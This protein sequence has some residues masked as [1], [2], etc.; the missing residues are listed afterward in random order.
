[1]HIISKIMRV[2]QKGNVRVAVLGVFGK[3]ALACAPTCELLFRDPIEA[4]RE[5]VEEIKEKEDADFDR[6]Y[7]AQRDMGG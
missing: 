3:D 6:V 4:V 2:F 7:L 5:T 1:M